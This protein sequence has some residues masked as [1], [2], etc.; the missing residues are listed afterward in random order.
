MKERRVLVKRGSRDTGS[1]KRIDYLSIRELA[2][3]SRR[4]A[5]KYREERA[6][7]WQMKSKVAQLKMT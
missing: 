6:L 3:N 2:G 7:H 5:T 1:G 4:L